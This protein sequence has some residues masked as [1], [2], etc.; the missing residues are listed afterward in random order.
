MRANPV[1]ILTGLILTAL[2]AGGASGAELLRDLNF[3]SDPLD[4]RPQ[5]FTPFGSRAVF[6]A[7]DDRH[8]YEP[9]ITD[10]TVA[11]SQLL[12]DIWPGAGSSSIGRFTVVGSRIFFIA[13]DETNFN[14]LWVTDGTPPGTRIV[15]N[16]TPN[17]IE[18]RMAPPTQFG[19]M[20]SLNGQLYFLRRNEQQRGELWRSDGT[21]QGTARIIELP[22]TNFGFIGT[23]QVLGNRLYFRWH[24]SASGEELWSSDGT[25]AGTGMVI[26]LWPGT[27]SSSPED[28]I[29]AGSGVYFRADDGSRGRELWYMPSSGAIPVAVPDIAP[30]N[31]GIDS[32]TT[33]VE[34]NRLIVVDLKL[35]NSFGVTCVMNGIPTHVASA[36][37]RPVAATGRMY[38]L[39][40]RVNEF[41][42]WVTDCTT[43]GTRLVNLFMDAGQGISAVEM[44]AIGP[45]ILLSIY[46]QGAIRMRLYFSDGSATGTSEIAMTGPRAPEMPYGAFISAG[47]Y[48][49]FLA[50]E[51][52]D[53]NVPHNFGLPEFSIWRSDG[54]PAG[55]WRVGSAFSPPTT[56]YPGTV[57]N[58]LLYMNVEDRQYGEETFVSNGSP[59]N[60]S[61]LRDIASG[62]VT[63]PSTPSAGWSVG[64]QHYFGA[65]NELGQGIFWRTDGTSGGTMPVDVGGVAFGG[66][67][68]V[69]GRRIIHGGSD[70]ASGFEPRAFDVDTS[71][72]TLLADIGPGEMS[73]FNGVC[74]SLPVVGNLVLFNAHDGIRGGIFVT[75][76]TPAG[77]S[78]LFPIGSPNEQLEI[79]RWARFGNEIVFDDNGDSLWRTDGSAAGTTRIYQAP[80]PLFVDDMEESNGLVYFAAANPSQ[81]FFRHL[82]RTDG[83]SQGTFQLDSLTGTPFNITPFGSLTAFR[84]DC[85]GGPECR[86]YLT[87]GTVA[88]TRRLA[89]HL[90]RGPSRS[91]PLP[92]WRGRIYVHG[93]DAARNERTYGIYA[94]D[95]IAFTREIP[96]PPELNRQFWPQVVLADRLIGI[97]PV[98][99][100]DHF[101]LWYSDGTAQGTK[102]LATFPGANGIP[103]ESNASSLPG[104]IYLMGNSLIFSADDG[105]HGTEPWIIPNGWPS[106]N[107]DSFTI[108]STGSASLDV[109]ANDGDFNSAL[110]GSTLEIVST[111]VFG[112]ATVNTSTGT[113]QYTP[114]AGTAGMD[115][116]TYRVRDTEGNLSNVA[117]V[118][119]LV[120]R[121]QGPAP[122][123]N[124]PPPPPPPGGG[125][126]GGGGPLD[127]ISLM[128]IGAMLLLS[129]ARIVQGS[130][131]KPAGNGSGTPR[132]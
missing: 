108:A 88:G 3:S 92:V 126:S 112:S 73:G 122:A 4:S 53:P 2:V 128:L 96:L 110:D 72:D 65:R 32:I 12:A 43:A 25:A 41:E 79:C 94:T 102:P 7:A 127:P 48:A 20:A 40:E 117:T 99:P 45:G 90:V 131:T 27:G 77:T 104:G 125:G 18:N 93:I 6:V 82:W 67:E 83:T 57:H 71:T 123:T 118:A 119:V 44:R 51:Y 46:E 114:N 103:T 109:L 42:L 11:G 29:F 70:G 52:F 91:Q 60:W 49:Y 78:R 35:Q 59:G 69:L 36:G 13:D 130:R 116:L 17:G 56:S 115:E 55:T 129:R 50:W 89:S 121:P 62:V 28:F 95:G 24:T 74:G 120:S 47:A 23:L 26:D 19:G 85:N 14:E 64:G 54:T 80:F 97:N 31:A 66:S 30:G 9:W 1:A 34:G 100:S 38:F 39:I 81:G 37:S 10:G 15:A 106:A 58:G 132:T 84:S 124:P 5:Q 22:A 86:L 113:I 105:L 107:Y 75:D 68:A 111:P 21:A 98:G 61:L 63:R 101:D 16:L 76:G 87:D 33:A 8:G